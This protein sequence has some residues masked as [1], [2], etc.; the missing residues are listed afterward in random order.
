MV[1]YGSDWSDEGARLGLVVVSQVK[2]GMGRR[3]WMKK[4]VRAGVKEGMM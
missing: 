4:E 3:E 2:L 1:D